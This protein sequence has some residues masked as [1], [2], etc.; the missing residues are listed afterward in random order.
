MEIAV[1]L[2]IVNAVVGSILVGL[3]VFAYAKFKRRMAELDELEE[4]VSN[5]CLCFLQ[6]KDNPDSISIIEDYSALSDT[7]T[8]S[9]FNFPS[10]E[11]F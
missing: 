11:G 8:T 10:R 7:D 5:L 6:F 1:I 3:F 9:G 4:T 2:G